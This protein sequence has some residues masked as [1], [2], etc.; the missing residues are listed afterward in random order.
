LAAV[1]FDREH[2]PGSVEAY[3]ERVAHYLAADEAPK[4]ASTRA[5]LDVLDRNRILFKGQF[6]RMMH[7]AR[8]AGKE[9]A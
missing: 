1:A 8:E 5:L 9:A 7:E 3:D 6:D 4:Q 2:L